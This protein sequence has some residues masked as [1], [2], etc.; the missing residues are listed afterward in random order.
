MAPA[1]LILAVPAMTTPEMVAA[2]QQRAGTR[3][4]LKV[5]VAIAGGFGESGTAE[6]RAWQHDLVE[7]CRVAGVRLVGPNC[8]GIVD[9]KNRVD[10][11]F[12]TGV[13]R[14]PGG[15]SLLRAIA[16]PLAP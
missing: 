8:V 4:D 3:K 16:A 11:T 7:G 13:W 2:I 9:N 14:R 15:V 6:G 10:T 12:L 1:M 5:V